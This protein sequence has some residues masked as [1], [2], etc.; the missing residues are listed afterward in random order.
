MS[1]CCDF[2]LIVK[3]VNSSEGV[4]PMQMRCPM[5]NGREI[6]PGY[7][8]PRFRIPKNGPAC[9]NLASPASEIAERVSR[10]VRVPK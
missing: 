1:S 7:T 4:E 2:R 3:F 6:A 9:L 8:S 5:I 10:S